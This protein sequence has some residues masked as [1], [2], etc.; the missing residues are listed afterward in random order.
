[1]Q[2]PA[3]TV[4]F[5]RHG[6]SVANSTPV[7]QGSDSPLSPKGLAQAEKI[8]DR[9]AL[10][11]F[12]ALIASPLRRAKQTAQAV[13]KKTAKDIDFS[14][15]FV[16]HTKPSGVGG[17]PYTDKEASG[18]WRVWQQT[19]FT[20]GERTKDG[21]NYDDIV[22]RADK[23]LDYLLARP[24]ANLAVVTHGYFLCT[25]VARILI[26]DNLTGPMLKRFQHRTAMQNTGITVLTYTNAFEEDF[27]WRLWTFNDHSHFA[28]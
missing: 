16:E 2:P 22:A 1:M 5:V 10:V 3:K 6:Q 8:A 25:M 18:T 17:K 21:E 9:L 13:A 24:E 11:E 15:L 12:E 23:A 14:D 19:Q 27:A 20:S 28:E 4:Y 26:G 7:F